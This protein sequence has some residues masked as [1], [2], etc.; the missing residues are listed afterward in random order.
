MNKKNNISNPKKKKV[1]KLKKF[2]IKNKLSSKYTN[3]SASSRS[4]INKL[5][6]KNFKKIDNL[7]SGK[8]MKVLD[9]F[10]LNQLEYEKAVYYDKRSFFKIYCDMLCREHII[11]FTFF[12][13]NDYNI[14]YIKYARFL[15]LLTTDMAM[16]VFFF[17]DDSM[18]KIFLNYGKYNFIQQIPQI[19]IRQ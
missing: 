12:V 9:E 8:R 16:N 17:S 7:I 3:Y 15:F 18:H 5:N 6:K 1:I 10:E 13:C 14:I 19:I 11:L 4:A 2:K